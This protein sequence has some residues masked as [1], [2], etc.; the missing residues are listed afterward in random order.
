[1]L[2]LSVR[3][4][5]SRP[6][7]VSGSTKPRMFFSGKILKEYSP[8]VYRPGESRAGSQDAVGPVGGQGPA[9]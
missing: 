2:A 3:A 4:S 1:M 7:S 8:V 5:P 9:G 6:W